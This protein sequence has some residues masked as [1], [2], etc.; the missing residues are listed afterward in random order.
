MC[1]AVPDMDMGGYGPLTWHLLLTTWRG[2]AIWDVLIVAALA[3][4]VAGLLRARLIHTP[5]LPWYRVVAFLLG[6]LTV[7]V[8]VNTAIETYSHV[9]FWV[10]M[11]QH[12][13]LIM[14]APALLV[15]GS[16]LTLLLQVT[17]GGVRRRV[18]SV[19]HSSPVALLNHPVVGFLVYGATIVGTHLTSFM[20]QMMLHPWL[21]QAEHILYLGGGYLFLLPLLGNEP[22]RWNPPHLL[23]LVMLFIAMAPETVVGIVLLQA[24]H[25]LFPAYADIHRMW[26]PTPLADL[27]RGGGIMWAFGDGLMM[28]F[29]VGV[30]LAYVTHAASN[31]TAGGWLEAVRR[32]T[33]VEHLDATGGERSELGGADLDADESALAAYNRMLAR[34]HHVPASGTRP[35]EGRP[36]V[37]EHP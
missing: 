33:L 26:G 32:N 7:V 24:D 10:H 1:S 31:A 4:Y 18:E 2:N 13:L 6:L 21:H 34:L 17:S 14:V 9:L 16:P 5:G 36:P 12:L 11:V 35:D 19:L 37:G 20:Q 30:M 27:N 25:E 8:S 22:I 23:R 15:V 29:I 3:S 28:V